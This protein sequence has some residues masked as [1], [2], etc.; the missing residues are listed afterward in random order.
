MLARFMTL[1]IQPTPRPVPPRTR[2][3]QTA[4]ERENAAPRCTRLASARF[5][6]RDAVS[7]VYCSRHKGHVGT[8]IRARREKRHLSAAWRRRDRADRRATAGRRC[9]AWAAPPVTTQRGFELAGSGASLPGSGAS[10]VSGWRLPVSGLQGEDGEGRAGPEEAADR[11]RHSASPVQLH[12]VACD[13]LAAESP[14]EGQRAPE[15]RALCTA[16]T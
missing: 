2:Q 5:L 14:G 12:S 7:P 13:V 10:L 1:L 11:P 8:G 6:P 3:S 9:T 15:A 4:R 16:S